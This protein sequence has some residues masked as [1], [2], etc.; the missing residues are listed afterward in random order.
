[1]SLMLQVPEVSDTQLARV[2]HWGAVD[3]AINLP[4]VLVELGARQIVALDKGYL[5]LT[6]QGA[7]CSIDGSKGGGD[8]ALSVSNCFNWG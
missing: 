1:M 7:V 3:E 6:S 8:A 4:D 2:L 5:V